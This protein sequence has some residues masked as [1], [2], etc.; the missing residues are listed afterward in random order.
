MSVTV[1]VQRGGG[2]GDGGQPWGEGES[3]YAAIG[4]DAAVRALTERFYDHVEASSPLVR[5]LHPRDLGE[6]RQKLYEFLTGWL[7]G[8]Q[9]Y[10][11]RR[12]HPR[13]RMRHAHVPI[14]PEGVSEWLR[15]MRLAMDDQGID[16]RLRAFLEA[17]FTH[18]AE[19]MRNR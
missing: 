11:Q 14:D 4:G 7:G 5:E 18:T 8:P 9:L 6:S 19:F 13:L 10:I 15:C 1:G 2:E 17:R 12:G 16:G 3:P